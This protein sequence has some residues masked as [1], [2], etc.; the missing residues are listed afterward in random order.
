MR[1]WWQSGH[2]N[3]LGRLGAAWGCVSHC[4]MVPDPLSRK[5]SAKRTAPGCFPW[6]L[7]PNPCTGL[8]WLFPLS[9]PRPPHPA[10]QG[11]QPTPSGRPV[12]STHA[13]QGADVGHGI[14]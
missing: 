14:Q 12:T 8:P 3:G 11:A 2:A 5:D 4:Q 9:P 6:E 13:A 10:G 7:V 1:P